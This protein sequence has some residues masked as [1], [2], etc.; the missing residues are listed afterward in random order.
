[1]K[2]KETLIQVIARVAIIISGLFSPAI[3]AFSIVTG[4]EWLRNTTAIVAATLMFFY[5]VS[6]TLQS[7][8]Q[9]TVTN[10]PKESM[11]TSTISQCQCRRCLR[12]RNEGTTLGPLFLPA[13]AT[14]MIVCPVCGDK[15]CIHAHEAPCAKADLHG[16][17]L[18]VAHHLSRPDTSN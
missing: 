9:G 4:N 14:Q 3:I 2:V 16:H 11:D 8:T 10:Q 5:F 15:R 17:N 6:L 13:E 7:S 18:W 12:N 1:M